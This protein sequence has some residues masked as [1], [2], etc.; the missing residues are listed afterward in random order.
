MAC[1]LIIPSAGKPG[2]ISFTSAEFKKYFGISSIRQRIEELKTSYLISLHHNWFPIDFELDPLFDFHFA[3]PKDVLLPSNHAKFVSLTAANFTPG[4]FKPNEETK[5]W[6]ILTIQRSADF[7]RPFKAMETIRQLYDE[8]HFLKVLMIFPMKRVCDEGDIGLNIE[9]TYESLFTLEEKRFFTLLNPTANYPFPFERSELARFYNSSRS[10]VHFA[11]DET[12]GRLSAYAFASGVPVVGRKCIASTLSNNLQTAPTF[13]EVRNDDYASEIIKALANQD[14][15]RALDCVQE[16]GE[17]SSQI[18]LIKFL[19]TTFPINGGYSVGDL[20]KNNL[21]TRIAAHHIGKDDGN[22]IGNGI[23]GFMD[24]VAKLPNNKNLQSE[25]ISDAYPER[26]MNFQLIDENIHHLE[27][28]NISDIN[29]TIFRLREQTSVSRRKYAV[30]VTSLFS[31][32]LGIPVVGYL[33]KKVF[34][35][36]RWSYNIFKK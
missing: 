23:S 31:K 14:G 27:A 35:I 21:D 1:I 26:C 30:L 18:K 15:N 33:I 25:L 19:N 32:F 13:Y 28:H 8:G 5:T 24:S 34:I 2:L 9:K 29:L 20:L 3:N 11:Q 10:F 12:R 4:F 16:I 36:L 22:S 7:K 17:I 6:D